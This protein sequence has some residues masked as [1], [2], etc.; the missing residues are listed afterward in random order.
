VPAFERGQEPGVDRIEAEVIKLIATH[1]RFDP[2]DL[3]L[4]S[5]LEDLGVE[6]LDLADL[7][8]QLET[9]FGRPIP[10]LYSEDAYV[11]AIGDIVQRVRDVL[12]EF[13]A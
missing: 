6:S 13:K 10:S 1:M 8:D 11:G 7:I 3:S 2:G 12:G 9:R 5:R 4:A